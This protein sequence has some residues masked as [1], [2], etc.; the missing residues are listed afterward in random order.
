MLMSLPFSGVYL[1]LKNL[2]AHKIKDTAGMIVLINMRK[3]FSN[4]ITTVLGRAGVK[5]QPISK[6]SNQVIPVTSDLKRCKVEQ[7]EHACMLTKLIDV[8]RRKFNTGLML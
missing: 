8:A 4:R 1:L 2:S 6:I 5:G 3:S 7:C